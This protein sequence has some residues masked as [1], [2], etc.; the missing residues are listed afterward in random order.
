MTGHLKTSL[1]SESVTRIKTDLSGANKA[2]A[3]LYPGERPDRQPVHTV[4]GGAQL[5][6]AGTIA[7]LGEM[8]RKSFEEYAPN[9]AVLAVALFVRAP[10]RRSVAEALPAALLLGTT[11]EYALHPATAGISASPSTGV[12][13]STR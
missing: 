1:S 11:F 7:R 4:Y 2:H 13:I 6:K 3:L 8:G 12:I 9:F 5:F 10:N